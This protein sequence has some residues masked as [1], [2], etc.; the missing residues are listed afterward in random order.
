MILDYVDG[1]ENI[2]SC[3]HFCVQSYFNLF[4][5]STLCSPALCLSPLYRLCL[6]RGDA[7]F[8]T[9][10]VHLNH[11][12]HFST[13]ALVARYARLGQVARGEGAYAATA[14]SVTGTVCENDVCKGNKK[15]REGAEERRLVL[16][17]THLLFIQI[18]YFVFACM[19]VSLHVF[20][21][22]CVHISLCLC[23]LSFSFLL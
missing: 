21:S 12:S 20:V 10:S 2:G 13:L 18:E 6:R 1:Q 4:Y 14:V 8:V 22:Q 23:V 3:I 9:M 19:T 15:G 16:S 5:F 7:I 17:P 11:I